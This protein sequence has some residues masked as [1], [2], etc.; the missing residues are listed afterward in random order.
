MV[1]AADKVEIY[2]NTIKGHKSGGLAGFN[3]AIGFATNE[4]DVGPN[5][6][7]VKLAGS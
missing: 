2:N 7:V 3:L 6:A 4:I 5:P 1:L